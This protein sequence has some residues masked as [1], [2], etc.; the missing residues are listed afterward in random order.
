MNTTKVITIELKLDDGKTIALPI[1]EARK[2]YEQ[3]AELFGK[4]TEKREITYI[5]VPCF[6]PYYL[7]TDPFSSPYKNRRP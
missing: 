6:P 2:L 4:P 7:P 3:L 5:P 1:D